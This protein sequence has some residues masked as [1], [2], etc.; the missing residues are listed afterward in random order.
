MERL[1]DPSLVSRYIPDQVVFLVSLVAESCDRPGLSSVETS[2]PRTALGSGRVVMHN[3]HLV[4]TSLSLLWER[5]RLGSSSGAK[6]PWGQNSH[7]SDWPV[8]I[9]K[10]WMPLGRRSGYLFLFLVQRRSGSGLEEGRGSELCHLVQL[11]NASW[12][13]ASVLA[14]HFCHVCSKAGPQ[15]SFLE[16]LTSSHP[17]PCQRE[18]GLLT[19]GQLCQGLSAVKGSLGSGDTELAPGTKHTTSI[20]GQCNLVTPGAKGK[21]ILKVP[22]EQ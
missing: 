11:L 5:H 12:N 7:L 2:A 16:S 17:G 6:G 20:Y 10:L 3:G 18:V 4:S 14:G 13:L 1:N 21:L 9:W 19:C 22:R 8:A 15:N